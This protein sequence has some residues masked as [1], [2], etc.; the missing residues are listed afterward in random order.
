MGHIYFA[1]VLQGSESSGQIH[2]VATIRWLVRHG[3]M[4]PALPFDQ[5]DYGAEF[6]NISQQTTATLRFSRY[7][8][9]LAR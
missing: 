2:D 7:S 1:F 4:S 5:I 9:S 3:L 6:G 8:N